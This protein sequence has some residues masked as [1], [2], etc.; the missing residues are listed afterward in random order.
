MR[1]SR[2]RPCTVACLTMTGV[3]M[4]EVVIEPEAHEPGHTHQASHRTAAPGPLDR[5]TPAPHYT[6]A[7]RA[8]ASKRQTGPADS[9]G[10]SGQEAA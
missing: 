6:N 9:A 3:R 8:R 5:A 2:R 1:W 10:R 7:D 4:L